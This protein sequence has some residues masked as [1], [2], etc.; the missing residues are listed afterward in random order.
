MGVHSL[1]VYE[2]AGWF[3][4]FSTQKEQSS[5]GRSLPGSKSHYPAGRCWRE[6]DCVRVDGNVHACAQVRL[7]GLPLRARWFTIW[8]VISQMGLA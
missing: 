6:N 8:R 3:F 2:A 4:P 5:S 7:S 1:A